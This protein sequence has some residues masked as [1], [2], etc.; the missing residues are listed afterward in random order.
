VLENK[1]ALVVSRSV[2]LVGNAPTENR[3]SMLTLAFP[4]EFKSQTTLSR[5]HVLKKRSLDFSV[6]F[7]YTHGLVGKVNLYSS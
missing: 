2:I 6:I 1:Q 5:V 7:N 3:M 4:I